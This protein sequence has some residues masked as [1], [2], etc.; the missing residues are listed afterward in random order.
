M[1]GRLWIRVGAI[2]GG[3]AVAAGAFGAHGLETRLEPKMLAV[4]ET[5]VKYQ[6]AHA[7]AL[8]LVGML[9]TFGRCTRALD[10]AGW[11]FAI[12]TVL[13][14]GSLYALVLS[15]VRILGAI[16]PIGG[17][18]FLVGWAALASHRVGKEN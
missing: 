16:T 2:S 14:S 15:D 18:G 17:V 9:G 7:L 1:N 13:F 12:G 5:A 3:L 11:A 8:I 6:M 10:V 4:F